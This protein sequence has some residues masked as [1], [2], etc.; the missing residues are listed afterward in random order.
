MGILFPWEGGYC[1][2]F[3]RQHGK[4]SGT[5]VNHDKLPCEIWSLKGYWIFN[6]CR[7]VLE[8]SD[9]GVPKNAT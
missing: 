8:I 5:G 4:W 9:E 7:L 1:N 6:F 3:F 2:D